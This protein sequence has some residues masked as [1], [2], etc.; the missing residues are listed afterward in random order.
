MKTW[1]LVGGVNILTLCAQTPI[2][3][4]KIGKCVSVSKQSARRRS[5]MKKF[6]KL[7]LSEISILHNEIFF[8]GQNF[9]ILA[10]KSRKVCIGNLTSLTAKQGVQYN[11][12][13]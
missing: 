5:N 13:S 4:P 3:G 10:H 11:F 2:S 12:T 9:H 6:I 7:K 8:S 1:A